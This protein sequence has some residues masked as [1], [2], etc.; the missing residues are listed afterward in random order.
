MWRKFAGKFAPLRCHIVICWW[1]SLGRLQIC[2]K[3]ARNL[4]VSDTCDCFI[5]ELNHDHP[6]RIA[7]SSRHKLH[8]RLLNFELDKSTCSSWNSNRSKNGKEKENAKIQ[9]MFL[10][11]SA[12]PLF[13]LHPDSS[14]FFH[15][16]LNAL[17]FS[18]V[19]ELAGRLP[20]FLEAE[21]PVILGHDGPWTLCRVARICF[22]S[23]WLR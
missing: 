7:I 10:R 23:F 9:Q 11:T 14:I 15:H 18:S 1:N 17:I 5:E 22:F 12:K 19:T 2:T 6:F 13:L 3:P 8:S 21:N 20:R 16:G 4:L